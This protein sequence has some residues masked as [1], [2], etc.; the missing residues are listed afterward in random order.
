MALS[1]EEAVAKLVVVGWE[2]VALAE[3]K[4]AV[5]AHLA[6]AEPLGGTAAPLVEAA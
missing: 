3:E 6:P 1:A 2:R 4:M 5:E